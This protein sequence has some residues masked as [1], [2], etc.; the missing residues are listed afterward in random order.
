MILTLEVLD[1]WAVLS[2]PSV[3]FLH[4]SPCVI[5]AI[6]SFFLQSFP[7]SQWTKTAPVVHGSSRLC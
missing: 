6:V 7:D 3:D 1:L 2:S 5:N 4:V